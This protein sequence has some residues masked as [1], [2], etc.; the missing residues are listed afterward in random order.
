MVIPLHYLV[1]PQQFPK[2]RT[3]H[4]AVLGLDSI[5]QDCGVAPVHDVTAIDFQLYMGAPGDTDKS[6][7][8]FCALYG[9]VLEVARIVA[10]LH[11]LSY[12]KLDR[13]VI[14]APDI[15]GIGNDMQLRSENALQSR[16]NFR[17][18]LLEQAG[19]VYNIR[20][21]VRNHRHIAPYYHGGY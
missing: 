13:H 21:A 2:R 8:I 5:C 4:I 16:V 19:N 1:R 14:P 11:E 17:V 9:I 12:A 6:G 3:R 15:L 20:L 18:P 10:E 7:P